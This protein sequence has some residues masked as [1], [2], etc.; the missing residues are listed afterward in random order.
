MRRFLTGVTAFFAMFSMA[1]AVSAS[2][3][4]LDQLDSELDLVFSQPI[5]E[6]VGRQPIDIRVQSGGMLLDP[7][8]S[9]VNSR[10]DVIDLLF[11]PL[12]IPEFPG[13]AILFIVQ[14]VSLCTLSN[15]QLIGCAVVDGNRSAVE[16]RAARDTTKQGFQVVTSGTELVAHELGHNFG[17]RHRTGGLM[18][19]SLNDSVALNRREAIAISNSPLVQFDVDGAAFVDLV[20]IRVAPIIPVPLPAGGVL[21]AGGLVLLALGRR[22]TARS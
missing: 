16:L 17:L 8:L 22:R 2:T 12:P 4:D 9:T 7:R 6:S 20:A 21:L 5:F 18:N 11:N 15:L 10:R 3:I 14:N 13:A 1:G 19:A